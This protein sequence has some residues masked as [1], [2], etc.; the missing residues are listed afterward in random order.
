MPSPAVNAQPIQS[1]RNPKR[2]QRN[3]SEDSLA[4]RHNPKRLRRSG[5][6]SETFEPPESA[7]TNGHVKHQTSLSHPN[8]HASNQRDAASDTASLAIRN[9]ASDKVEKRRGGSREEGTVLVCHGQIDN[10]RQRL[11]RKGRRRMISMLCP[12]YLL[13]LS[14]SETTKAQV[15]ITLLYLVHCL[16]KDQR[17]GAAKSTQIWASHLSL[18]KSMRWYGGTHKSITPR[19]L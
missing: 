5:L 3:T 17:D 11:M 2:R 4:L 8:G 1:L 12:S 9:R 6:T 7:K 13:H 10:K 16:T 15:S 14:V 18:R 19:S